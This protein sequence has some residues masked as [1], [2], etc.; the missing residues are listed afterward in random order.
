MCLNVPG[1]VAHSR[2]SLQQL[3]LQQRPSKLLTDHT[4]FLLQ[5]PGGAGEAAPGARRRHRQLQRDGRSG[6]LG[7]RPRYQ[8]HRPPQQVRLQLECSTGASAAPETTCMALSMLVCSLLHGR[9][10]V[11]QAGGELS[12]ISMHTQQQ[13]RPPKASILGARIFWGWKLAFPASRIGWVMPCHYENGAAQTACTLSSGTSIWHT[14]RSVQERCMSIII[15]RSAHAQPSRLQS[16][17]RACAFLNPHP[18][19]PPQQPQHPDGHVTGVSEH[20]L[21]MQIALVSVFPWY[22][23]H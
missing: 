5:K 19:L 23:F 6:L 22:D 14:H 18:P 12:F 11:S 8:P 17:H 10:R 21:T 9:L 16:M 20:Q 1:G 4:C 13:S 3:W 15:H 7:R 2:H